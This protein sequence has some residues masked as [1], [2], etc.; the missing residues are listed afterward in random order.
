[1]AASATMAWPQGPGPLDEARIHAANDAMGRD[2][3]GPIATG[4]RD[5]YDDEELSVPLPPPSGLTRLLVWRA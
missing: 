3:L 4:S 5:L 1:M 2:G